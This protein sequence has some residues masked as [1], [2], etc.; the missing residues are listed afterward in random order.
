MKKYFF[1]ILVSATYACSNNSVSIKEVLETFVTYPFSDP[2]AIPQPDRKYYPYYRF[3]GFANES[4]SVEWKVVTMENKYIEVHIFPEIGGKIWGAMEK[5]TGNEFIYYNSVVKFRDIALRGP[6][7]SGGVEL[8]FGVKG[9]TPSVSTPVDYVIRNNDDGSVSCFV[10]TID[11][12]TRTWWETEINLHPDNAYFTTNTRWRNSTPFL[13]PYYQWSNAAYQTEGDLEMI[14]P[15]THQISHGGEAYRW[16]I[17]DNDRDLSFYENNDFGGNKSY[18]I[19]GGPHSFYAAYWHDLNFG[20]GH[21]SRYGDKL[22]KKVWIWSHARS[23]GIWEDLL[24][25]SDGQYVELQSGRLF[26]QA[27]TSSTHTPFKH[28]GFFPYTFDEF[29]EYWYPIM[30]IGGV[31]AANPKGVLNVIKGDDDQKLYL[32]PIQPIKDEIKIFFGDELKYNFD[33]DLKSL[34]V[35]E[36]NIPINPKHKP[37]EVFVGSRKELL[38][39]ERKENLISGRPVKSPEGFDWSSVFGLYTEGINWVYQNRFDLAYESFKACLNKDPLYGLSYYAHPTDYVPGGRWEDQ[40]VDACWDRAV[41]YFGGY[42][43]QYD[44]NIGFEMQLG[45]RKERDEELLNRLLKENLQDHDIFIMGGD[46]NHSR[47]VSDN[48]TITIVLA[49]E[50]TEEAVRYA[51]EKGHSFVGSRVDILPEFKKISVDENRKLILLDIKNYD[52][53]IWIKNG[54]YYKEG[55]SVNYSDFKETVLRFQIEV[56]GSTF[57]SQAFYIY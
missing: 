48:A 55:N 46:D 49:E 35:W 44:R 36:I 16:P 57:Y 25:D 10:G 37:L 40:I 17:D 8:N 3:D 13:Q 26:N 41:E 47:K 42:I 9:H 31:V 19:I 38:Y 30:N 23:G 2:N 50:L 43:T 4:D 5:S 11:L 45:S 22:G 52:K 6:W 51:L 33:L 12:L 1:I 32:S 20:A 7:T 27:S 39:S 14:F 18:H 28:Y 15:G 29:K 53:I 34:E 24:T 54:E 56:N 21:Y